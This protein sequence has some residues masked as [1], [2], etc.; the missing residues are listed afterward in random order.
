MIRSSRQHCSFVMCSSMHSMRLL[1]RV[2]AQN[3]MNL[4]IALCVMS[5]V[6]CS[7]TA[8][9][10]ANL[11]HQLELP[12]DV[13]DKLAFTHCSDARFYCDSRP[14][15]FSP[16]VLWFRCCSRSAVSVC[17]CAF[18]RLNEMTSDRDMCYDGSSKPNSR[19]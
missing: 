9:R 16:T 3:A 2:I 17:L 12:G 18:L 7:R 1:F 4:Y 10:V 11:Q 14:T 19:S 6:L 13:V 15:F 5:F 8:G